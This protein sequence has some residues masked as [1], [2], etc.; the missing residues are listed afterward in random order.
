MR[1][2]NAEKMYNADAAAI[3]VAGIPSYILMQ[4]AAGHLARIALEVMGSNRTAVVLCGAGNNGGDGVAAAAILRQQGVSVRCL[5]VGRQEKMTHDTLRMEERLRQAG[6]ELEDFDPE[7]VALPGQLRSAGAV[8][9]ALFGIGLHRPLAGDALRAVRMMNETGAVVIAADIP[10]GVSADTGAVLGEAPRCVR[11]VTFSRAKPGHFLEPGCIYCGQVD[12]CDIGI[13][14]EMV[15]AAETSVS[16][17]LPGEITL[18]RRPR[19]GHKGDF[20]KVLILGGSVGYTGAPNLCARAAVRTGAGLVFLG[21]PKDIYPVCAVKN[22]E[23]MPFPLPSDEEGRLT[24]AAV[25]AAMERVADADVIVAGPGLGRSD[26]IRRAIRDLIQ[27]ARVPIL[28]DADALWAVSDDPA[29]LSR[30]QAPLVIT[31]HAGEFHRLGGDLTG[32][33]LCDAGFFARQYG[34]ITLLKGHRTVVATPGGEDYIIAAGNP[35]M[36]KGGSG[37][38]LSGVLGA[39]LGQ[40][41]AAAAAVTGAWLHAAAGDAC[42]KELGEYGMTPTDIIQKLPIIMKEI[43]E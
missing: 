13:P 37:D 38:V 26:E 27:T 21:V 3:H 34:C 12:V 18:P 25:P 29:I 1:L 40:Q 35:G 9:D 36:A 11:T 15:K 5:L 42:A 32:D 16:V 17:V 10:S 39:L 19:L 43:T 31:P 23:A 22:D 30:A 4:N 7:D 20:G 8:I 6:G 14:P 41:E 2:S 33:R 28:L 24:A